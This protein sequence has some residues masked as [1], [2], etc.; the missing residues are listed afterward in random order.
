MEQAG[1]QG[2]GL[3]HPAQGRAPGVE[4]EA[5]RRD[6]AARRVLGHGDEGGHGVP[7]RPAALGIAEVILVGEGAVGDAQFAAVLI[8]ERDQDVPVVELVP[9]DRV[10]GVVALGA[11]DV[12]VG[13]ARFRAVEVGAGDEVDH[14][15]DRVGPV[16]RGGA[17]LQ[18]LDAADR[19][20][21][22]DIG[23]DDA[24]S[25]LTE[26]VGGHAAAVDQHQGAL[27]AEPAQVHRAGTF[28]ALGARIELIGVAEDAGRDRQVLQ[29]FENGGR[30]LLRQFL[31]ADD[32][33]GESRRGRSAADQRA[34]HHDLTDGG[35]V[36]HDVRRIR[37]CSGRQRQSECKPRAAITESTR[38]H[39]DVP[40]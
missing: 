28:R 1:R 13:P 37:L 38:R 24:R 11:V 30:V 17:V 22:D 23:V 9:E 39:T 33:H 32:V 20:H 40:P 2:A 29:Q 5:G 12:A 27:G 6:V 35:G 14:A 4:F 16:G 36:R 8:A 7:A 19:G 34:G 18:H 31:G 26:G 21:R 15:R 10:A 3:D 25:G